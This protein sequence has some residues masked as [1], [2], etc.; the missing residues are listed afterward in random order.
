MHEPRKSLWFLAILP[1]A[2]VENAVRA[3]QA[4]LAERFA[5]RRGLKIPVHITLEPPFR[6]PPDE[7]DA[8]CARLKEFFGKK[9]SFMLELKNFGVFRED[10][11]FI[12]VVPNLALL[13]LQQEL[14][15]FLRAPPATIDTAPRHAG[16]KPHL[17]VAN[18]D[19][20]PPVHRKIWREFR[21]R[22]FYARFEVRDVALLR[23]DGK[24]WQSHASFALAQKL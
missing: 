23:H 2:D 6:L 15:A 9:D 19:V 3:L 10:V 22:P 11:L 4:E 20:P 16:F 17:T 18:R 24:F 1:P 14:S 7:A 13:E 8:L 12:D 5:V 21:H